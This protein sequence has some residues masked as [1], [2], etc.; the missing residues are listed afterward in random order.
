M[1]ITEHTQK[2]IAYAVIWQGI[3]RECEGG[4]FQEDFRDGKQKLY[5][6]DFLCSGLRRYHAMLWGIELACGW[7]QNNERLR[8]MA[9]NAIQD[10]QTMRAE[11]QCG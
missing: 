6:Y 10:C 11:F 7:D 5:D 4:S 1:G 8:K 3:C 2:E 9:E